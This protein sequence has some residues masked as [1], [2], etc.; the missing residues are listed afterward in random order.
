MTY[1]TPNFL[2]VPVCICTVIEQMGYDVNIPLIGLKPNPLSRK[3]FL[4]WY[5]C[6]FGDYD[7][8][9][10]CNLIDLFFNWFF[11]TLDFN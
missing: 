4:H 11:F 5:N 10:W 3:N 6:I 2:V 7:F 9:Q 1:M 8:T